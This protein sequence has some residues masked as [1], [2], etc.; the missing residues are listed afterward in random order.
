MNVRNYSKILNLTIIWISNFPIL[1]PQ[2]EHYLVSNLSCQNC[3]L[4]CRKN[5]SANFT[6]FRL[7][8]TRTS[9][10][11]RPSR[12][13]WYSWTSRCTWTARISR[14]TS[15]VSFSLHSSVLLRFKVETITQRKYDEGVFPRWSKIVCFRIC[16]EVVEP[17]CSPCPPGEP[18]PPGPQGDQGSPYFS[19]TLLFNFQENQLI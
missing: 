16:E 13:K 4:F 12:Q 19:L 9:W 14:K 10:S 1:N 11:R 18:G 17:P 7:L 5:I 3:G 15:S 2:T 8:L 6:T